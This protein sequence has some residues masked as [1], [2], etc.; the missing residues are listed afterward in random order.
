MN[1]QTIVI[2]DFGG[3]YKELIARR[4]RECGVYS[5]ILPYDTDVEEVAALK[6]IGIIFT[7][8]PNSVY[9]EDSPKCSM[10]IFKLGV[11]VLGIC[12]GMQ[13]IC[14]LFGGTVVTCHASEYGTLDA[15]VDTTSDL[16]RQLSPEQPVLMSH[17]DMVSKLPSGF[18]PIASTAFC[19]VAA[20]EN[21]GEKIFGVQFHPEVENTRNGSKMINNFLYRV[22]GAAGDYSMEDYLSRKVKEVKERVGNKR[23][24]LGLSGGVDSS[25]CAALL[26]RAIPGQLVCIYVD[27]GFMRKGETQQIREAFEGRDLDFVYVDAKDR[28]IS[29]L[30]G[31]TDPE[32]KRKIIGAEFARTFEDEAKKHGSP[33]FLAQGTIYPD[34]VESGS[35]NKS[36]VIKSHHNVGGLPADLGFEGVIEP[37]SLL[38]KDEVRRLGI[39]LGLPKKLVWRQPF[40]GPGLAIRIVGEVTEEKLNILREADAIVREEIGRCRVRADQY[41]AVMTN[42]RS[43]GVMGDFR[44]YE[45]VIAVRAVRTGDFMT[46]EYARLP[47]PLLTRISSR[48]TN[49]VRGVNRVVYDITAKP[50]AT[51]EWE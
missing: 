16:F 50:P 21:F 13:L 25:V 32:Q 48:I 9:A 15:K 27:H 46:C 19:P 5:V 3:Q 35:K 45:N 24:L 29:K 40:P 36:A 47:Y 23:V 2:L 11:P 42:T 34:V 30:A 41:F 18:R 37:L 6:P 12:Y 7:G 26:S 33:E 14:H 17:T 38:F 8:G 10:G 22:C 44:T 20:F 1:N 43:V 49:E 39:L 31:V 51:I 28:F 4:V